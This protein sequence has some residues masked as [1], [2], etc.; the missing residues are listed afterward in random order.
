[1]MPK[2]FTPYPWGCES[3]LQHLPCFDHQAQ[4][5]ILLETRGALNH[6]QA[7][8]PT[9]CGGQ[10]AVWRRVWIVGLDTIKEA[11]WRR[12][13]VWGEGV[14]GAVGGSESASP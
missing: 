12:K 13:V 10:G 14:G 2:N 3:L 4:R 8:V 7:I 6:V 9:E 1:M 5:M 11:S